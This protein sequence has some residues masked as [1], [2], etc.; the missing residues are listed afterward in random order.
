MKTKYFNFIVINGEKRKISYKHLKKIFSLLQKLYSY[1]FKAYFFEVKQQTKLA[2]YCKHGRQIISKKPEYV[3][4]T[5]FIF[6]GKV[7]K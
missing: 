6:I 2:K 3:I 4:T 1:G 5:L 7:T